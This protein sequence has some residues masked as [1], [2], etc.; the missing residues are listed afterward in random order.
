MFYFCSSVTFAMQHV[1][2]ISIRSKVFR[3]VSA[4]VK[5]LTVSIRKSHTVKFTANGDT[6]TICV[7]NVYLIQTFAYNEVSHLVPQVQR[8]WTLKCWNDK[9]SH[10]QEI[11]KMNESQNLCAYITDI[12]W[13]VCQNFRCISESFGISTDPY[14]PPF[15]RE[16]ISSLWRILIIRIIFLCRSRLQHSQFYVHMFRLYVLIM[17]VHVVRI[18]VFLFAISSDYWR[19]LNSAIN[20]VSMVWKW[21]TIA[22]LCNN[23]FTLEPLLIWWKRYVVGNG[24]ETQQSLVPSIRSEV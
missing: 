22:V 19:L 1:P 15:L 18:N 12:V 14:F 21:F 11:R 3:Q 4:S 20:V 5:C 23:M 6:K 16:N 17:F 8:G 13:I 7:Q 2:K 10:T 24:T 9:Y